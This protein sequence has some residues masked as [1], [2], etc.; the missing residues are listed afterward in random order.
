MTNQEAF[1]KML[2]HLRSLPA[3]SADCDGTCVYN[4]SM[5]AVGALMTAEEQELYGDHTGDAA[6][7]LH[8]MARDGHTS[9]L[10]SLDGEMLYQMQE[11]HDSAVFWS[12]EDGFDHYGE[13]AVKEVAD[14]RGLVYTAPENRSGS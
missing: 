13:E 10:H 5:C 1:D 4:G 11:I 2:S 8:D 3:R 12:A 7:L 14:D 6:M 9:E